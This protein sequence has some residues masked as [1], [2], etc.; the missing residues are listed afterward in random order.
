MVAGLLASCQSKTDGY[1]IEGTLTGDAASGKAYLERSVYLSDPVVVDSTVVQ[2][3]S[4]T[5]SGKV[6]RPGLYYVIIDLNKP[7][8]SR[9]III[10]CFVQCFIW[11]TQTL[12]IREM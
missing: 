8:K 11:R 2:N 10:R 3:G 9:I 5:F 6:E 12:L 4:F 7:A 1:T